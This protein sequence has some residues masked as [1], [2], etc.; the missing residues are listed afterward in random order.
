VVQLN[1]VS[2]PWIPGQ[3][4]VDDHLRILCTSQGWPCISSVALDLLLWFCFDSFCF[5]VVSYGV[6]WLQSCKFSRYHATYG[7]TTV[8]KLLHMYNIGSLTY[9][10]KNGVP[11]LRMQW[12]QSELYCCPREA[13]EN[14]TWVAFGTYST[15]T[16][17]K[18][19][20]LLYYYY[21]IPTTIYIL[22]VV[23]CTRVPVLLLVPLNTEVL[24]D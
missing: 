1:L 3:L 22:L 23:P 15:C 8:G 12:L 6:Y 14:A 10:E 2:H 18:G 9:H 13:D 24:L 5:D 19:L 21:Y 17:Y 4:D 20:I 16:S 11:K 7:A